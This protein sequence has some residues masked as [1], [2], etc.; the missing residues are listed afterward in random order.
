MAFFEQ[1]IGVPFPWAKYYQTCVNDFVAGGM[2]NTSATTLTD[3][4]LF[5][6]DTENIRNSQSLVSHEMAHQWFGDLVTCKDWSHVWLNE[7]FATYY[8]VLYDGWKNGHDAL[9][10]DLYANARS[11]TS[12][13]SDTNAIVRR[14]YDDPF[15]MFNYLAY[16]KGG[17]V[18]HMLRSQ[19]GKDLYR[20]CI[21]TYLERHR[22]GN[23]TTEDLRAV[24]EELSGRPYDQFFDQW[25]YHAHYPEL[26]SELFVGRS[27][28]AGEGLDTTKTGCR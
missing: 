13:V 17:W 11:V 27:G 28:E 7:G 16:P 2:E 19:L 1:E 26:G 24:I 6:D 20:Q 3:A 14:N 25:L 23:V 8:Q 21:K 4:T 12:V 9:L 15:D 22:Y 10:Y 5:K 18:L